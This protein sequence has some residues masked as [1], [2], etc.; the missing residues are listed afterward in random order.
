MT[1]DLAADQSVF[2]ADFGETVRFR[3]NA[4]ATPRSITA[5]VNR[6]AVS[7]DQD[8]PFAGHRPPVIHVMARN[9]ATTGIDPTEIVDDQSEVEVAYPVGGTSR[10]RRIIRTV[11]ANTG[12]VLVEVQS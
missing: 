7:D 4:D 12:C 11:R 1:L 9:S 8:A 5:N 10:W 2:F 3:A 6:Q